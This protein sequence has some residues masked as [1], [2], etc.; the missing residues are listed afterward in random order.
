MPFFV[1][2]IVVIVIV[3]ISNANKKQQ[4][5][6]AARRAQALK[7]ATRT[8]R[9]EASS[10]HE[11]QVVRETQRT[12]SDA[13]HARRQEELKRRLLENRQ[14]REAELARAAQLAER[15]TERRPLERQAL[16]TALRAEKPVVTHEDDDC[17]GGSIH[18]GYHEGVTQFSAARPAAVAGNLG[19]RLA[20]EDE[21]IESEVRAAENAK[22][23]M[24]RIAK[25]P[26]LAQ[27]MIYSEI[28]GKPKSETA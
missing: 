19:H 1:F 9:N 4:A 15:P 24:A 10:I 22:R 18:D 5:A 20:D 7:E 2:L 6:A 8:V 16:Q 21:R 25:L 26:P 11:A 12:E 13:E 17:G 23:A 27:G 14:R 28:L 3:S